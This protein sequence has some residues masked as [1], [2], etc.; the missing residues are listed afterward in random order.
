MYLDKKGVSKTMTMQFR[1]SLII[2]AITINSKPYADM[3]SHV[4]H[5]I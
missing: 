4:N 5:L 1:H 3:L 2:E